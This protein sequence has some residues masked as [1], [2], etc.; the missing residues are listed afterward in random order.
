VLGVVLA[1]GL[2]TRLR[3]LTDRLPKPALPVL[4]APLASYALRRLAALGITRVALNTHHLPRELEAALE[5]HVPA[6]MTLRFAHEPELLGTGGGVRNAAAVL[7]GASPPRLALRCSSGASPPG[8]RSALARPSIARFAR[9]ART[10]PDRVLRNA[11]ALGEADTVVVMN[12]DILFWPDL[13]GALALHEKLGAI[14][15]MVVREDPRA[16]ELGAI[17]VDGEGRVR[18]LLGV[19]NAPAAHDHMFTGVHVLSPRAIEELPER[20]CIVRTAYRRWVDGG[21]V[22]AGFADTSDWRDLGTPREYLR[23]NLDLASGRLRFP[24]V[25][26]IGGENVIGEGATIAPGVR[27][28]RSVVWPGTRVEADADGAILAGDLRIVP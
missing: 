5:G 1:A 7:R 2:G 20:G 18:S 13:E 6:G 11:G 17:G 28:E 12:G 14:A 10:S 21:E 19:P 4:N 27:V 16:R 8:S 22:V 24:S 23:A 26:P 15:T 9:G 3:P 25:H